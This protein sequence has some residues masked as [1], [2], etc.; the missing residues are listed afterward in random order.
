MT[1]L[2]CGSWVKERLWLLCTVCA[3]QIFPTLQEPLQNMRINRG[4]FAAMAQSSVDVAGM[5]IPTYVRTMTPAA[6][7]TRSSSSDSADTEAEATGSKAQGVA[8]RMQQ[9]AAGIAR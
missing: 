9:E 1:V 3:V 7:S 4:K 6:S 5:A 8:S 2:R